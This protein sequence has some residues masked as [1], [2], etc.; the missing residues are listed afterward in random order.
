MARDARALA[1]EGLNRGHQRKPATLASPRRR[2]D[3]RHLDPH[4]RP[5]LTAPTMN[6]NHPLRRAH[7]HA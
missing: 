2:L 4:A 5:S 6:P 1:A 7:R 3:V